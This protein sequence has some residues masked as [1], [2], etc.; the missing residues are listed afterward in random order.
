[1]KSDYGETKKY[2]WFFHLKSR[3][4]NR[5]SNQQKNAVKPPNCRNY[6]GILLISFSAGQLN[7]ILK[8]HVV[9]RG[10][11]LCFFLFSFFL[12]CI[13]FSFFL[14]FFL[15]LFYVCIHSQLF[16]EKKKYVQTYC[17]SQHTQF[18][19]LFIVYLHRNTKRDT[20]E[21]DCV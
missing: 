11:F 5:I 8:L 7:Q 12:F 15:S 4:L 19:W 6:R 1:M 13:S 9:T 20:R 18:N 10:R 3:S 16:D 14:F 17:V 21:A 2:Q